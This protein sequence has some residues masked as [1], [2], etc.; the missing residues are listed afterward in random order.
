MPASDQQVHETQDN[1]DEQAE[2]QRIN[3]ERNLKLYLGFD[4]FVAD[5]YV[6]PGT[7]KQNKYGDWEFVVTVP[8]PYLS[9]LADLSNVVGM[10]VRIK[11]EKIKRGQGDG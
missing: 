1:E 11:V 6:Q 5:C 9:S 10:P 8:R 4:D 7:I 3:R 2:Q